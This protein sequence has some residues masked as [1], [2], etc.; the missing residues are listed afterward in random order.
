[1]YKDGNNFDKRNGQQQ[2]DISNAA[3]KRVRMVMVYF[4]TLFL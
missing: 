1:M 2:N 4:L 3:N